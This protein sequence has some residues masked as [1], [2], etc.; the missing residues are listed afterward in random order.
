[1][2][3]GTQIVRQGVDDDESEGTQMQRL[4]NGL[5]SH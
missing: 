4:E 5:S 1:M 3:D 2:T